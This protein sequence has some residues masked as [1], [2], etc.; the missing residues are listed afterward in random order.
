MTTIVSIISALQNQAELREKVYAEN[1]KR[2]GEQ[3][4]VDQNGRLHAPHSGYVWEDKVYMGGEYLG[5]NTDTN[6]KLLKIKVL[7]KLVGTLQ[8]F[9]GTGNIGRSWKGA[10]G[11]ETCYFYVQVQTWEANIV[12]PLLP[13]AGKKI[14]LVEEAGSNGNKEWKFSYNRLANSCSIKAGYDMS[15]TLHLFEESGLNSVPT[16][17]EPGRKKAGKLQER[18]SPWDGKLVRNEYEDGAIKS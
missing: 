7:S 11:E 13:V 12:E 10:D 18:Y 2:A 9:F 3:P 15:G 1:V 4:T 8:A 5:E 16:V 14:V 6:L 17:Y